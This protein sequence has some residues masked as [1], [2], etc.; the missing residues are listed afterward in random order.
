MSLTPNDTA[1]IDRTLT[2]FLPA[3]EAVA[4]PGGMPHIRGERGKRFVFAEYGCGNYGC[5]LPTNSDY[6]F[7][8]TSD[9]SEAA[10]VRAAL[11]L[12]HFPAGIVK[13]AAI[14]HLEGATFRKRPLF[15]LWREEATEVGFLLGKSFA[16]DGY[17]NRIRLESSNLTSNA[18]V[19][20]A[21]LRTWLRNKPGRT[22]KD[23]PE[24]TL[25]WASYELREHSEW[26]EERDPL[27]NSPSLGTVLKG[28]RGIERAALGFELYKL[29][30]DYM[31][32]NPLM[33]SI[34]HA[35]DFYLDHG[36][37][38]ADVHLGNIGKVLDEE[39][40]EAIAITDPGHAVFLDGRYDRLDIEPLAR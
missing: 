39:A 25:K 17:T 29:A 15:A 31:Q 38:L 18:R 36:I 11:S 32:N 3:I 1:W 30:V 16:T 34:H 23:I 2:A 40:Y 7:K 22:V 21:A 6:V 19:G 13:Y 24:E 35:M 4:P 28:G 14:Y 12:G 20:A 27:I 37:V 8:V 10:F 26:V 9:A 33:F 5:V